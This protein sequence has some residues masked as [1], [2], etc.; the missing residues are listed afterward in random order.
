MSTFFRAGKV[1]NLVK[2]LP[3]KLQV[4][5]NYWILEISSNLMFN[6]VIIVYLGKK[7]KKESALRMK[8]LH[9]LNILI[10][11]QRLKRK[12]F[13]RNFKSSFK[14]LRKQFFIAILGKAT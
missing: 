10:I 3:S 2:F 9:H 11:T 1:V 6:M 4:N 7:L 12:R 8:C 13:P 5:S 14:I